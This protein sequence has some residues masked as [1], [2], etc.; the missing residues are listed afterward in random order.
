MKCAYHTTEFAV[1]R[2]TSC[3]NTLCVACDHRIKGSPYCQDCIVAGI[4]ILHRS[5][6]SNSQSKIEYKS[7]SLASILGII[8]GLGAAYTGQI[9]K[10]LVHF[11]LVVGLWT[12]ADVFYK[13]IGWVFLLG[14]IGFYFFSIYDAYQMASKQNLGENI[15]DADNKL[16]VFL[17][18]KISLWGGAISFIGILAGINLMFPYLIQKF[19]PLLLIASGIFLLIKGFKRSGNITEEMF[20]T[21]NQKE[22]RHRDL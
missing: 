14:G 5:Q 19:W 6:E 18:T 20:H 1:S 13:S 17:R 2:C 21:E 10:S 3:R 11:V 12:L 15:I 22:L 16:K 8:P 4:E 7:P 9:I